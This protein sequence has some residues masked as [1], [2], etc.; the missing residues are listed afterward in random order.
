MLFFIHHKGYKKLYMI[1]AAGNKCMLLIW[2]CIMA[3]QLNAQNTE[4]VNNASIKSIKLFPGG[5]QTAYPIMALNG[6]D[7]LQLTFDDLDADIKNYYYSYQLCNADW[8]PTLLNTFE[9]TRG[10]QNV[11]ISQYRQS[12]IAFTRY[13]NYQ[14]VI[15]D[16]NSVP[17]VSGNYLLKVFLNGDTSQLVFT[18]RFMV[19]D[20][21]VSIAAQVQQPFNAQWYN[22]YQKLNISVS[23]DNRTRVFTPQDI[24]VVV[25]QN[26][27]WPTAL[28][29]NRPTI[30][31]GNYFEYSD[32][33]STAMPAGKEWRWIDLRSLRM[34]SERMVRIDKKSNSTDVIV[35]PD[36]ERRSQPYLY[37]RDINGMYTIESRDNNN[38]FWQ[39]DYAN[40][41]FS[42]F[43][44][45][46]QPY[47]GRNLYLFGE[48]TQYAT[49]P[50]AEMI[51][52]AERGAYEK[53]LLLKQGFYNYNYV[54][55]SV[56]G[57]DK[58]INYETAEGHY[59]DTENVYTILVYYRPF[60]AR[61][62]ELIGYT[63]V[64]SLQARQGFR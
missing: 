56:D 25:L 7:Q 62:D 15:P 54:T 17:S 36:G 49:D 19:V 2:L 29:L 5:D 28:Y 11:R 31:R 21:K 9:Y 33:A 8:S 59:W 42:F 58:T 26:Y 46:N 47:A 52:N 57:D 55:T 48:L 12:S 22:T 35:K 60:G 1:K 3:G 51:F 14:A 27:I 39:S 44:P 23:T 24:K 4:V 41:L 16:R 64:N 20:Q 18:K 37:Y 43:P 13:T 38:P 63:Q 34:I 45:G 32:E 53:T 61:A 50:S 10:F 6:G 30:F 40:V